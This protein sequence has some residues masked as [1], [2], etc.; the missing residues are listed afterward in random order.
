MKR[1]AG[2]RIAR[3]VKASL[4]ELGFPVKRVLLFGS[5]AQNTATSG[6]DI[7]IAVVCDPFRSSS[8]EERVDIHLASMDVDSRV[9][10]VTLHPKDFKRPFFTLGKEIERTGVEV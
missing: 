2:V 6:S 1:S 10:T 8:M 5:V 3:Q 9:E 4:L 7:D